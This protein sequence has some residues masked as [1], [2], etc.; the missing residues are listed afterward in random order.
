MSWCD[1]DVTFNLAV[2]KLTFKI[3]ETIKVLI[4]NI[5]QENWLENVGDWM[6]NVIV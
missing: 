3:L 5:L 6:C 1:L 4:V 2:V